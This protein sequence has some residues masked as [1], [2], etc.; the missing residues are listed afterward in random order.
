MSGRL[1]ALGHA[2][3]RKIALDRMGMSVMDGRQ[4][5]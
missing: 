5:T 1:R 3:A 2:P 4:E